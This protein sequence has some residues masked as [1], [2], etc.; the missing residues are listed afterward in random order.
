MCLALPLSATVR[1]GAPFVDGAVLQAGRPVPVWGVA[2]GG[3]C[4][5]VSFAGQE[6][7]ARADATGA[8]QVSLD[9]MEP[10]SEGRVLSAVERG[11]GAS[12]IVISDVLVGEVWVC[13]GQSNAECPLWG[14][15]PRFRD[16]NGALYAML[17]DMPDVRYVKTPNVMAIEPRRDVS[18]RWTKMTAHE[19]TDPKVAK[20]SAMG[21]YF[22]TLLASS[23]HVPVGL[24]DSTWG[25]TNI[26]AWTPRSGYE[27]KPELAVEC[28]WPS[29]T[30]D[31]W[32]QEMA[33][34]PISA[35]VQQPS[36]LWNAMVAPYVPMAVRGVIWYQG[37]HNN[38][39]AL[40]YGSKLHALY[41]G[42]SREFRNPDLRFRLVQLAPYKCSW[43]ELQL[44]QAKFAAEEKNAEIAIANDVG[45]LT[46]IHPNDKRTVAARLVALTLRHDY[47]RTD[48][49]SDS[50]TLASWRVADGAFV[51][52]FDHAESWFLYHDDKGDTSTGFEIAGADGVWHKARLENVDVPIHPK[53]GEPNFRGGVRGRELVVRA[54]DV[55]AP[56]ALRYLYSHP[57]FGALKNEV[58]LPLGAFRVD[59]PTTP[60]GKTQP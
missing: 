28:A 31:A 57:W 3:A 12:R 22:A 45:N 52:T 34:G 53:T 9:A 6:K 10:S 30:R 59:V 29:M 36:V 23:L 13:S 47:G 8:W 55:A 11:G 26:D 5:T 51:L 32:R 20:P 43:F 16:G 2:A 37:C 1:L 25:G 40:R 41:D 24:V 48:V 56:K 18:V 60:K 7:M 39:E 50:P 44:Q 27:G 38:G 58:G 19:L 33:K 46:D 14:P 42:W 35:A 21:F 15:D 17:T 4:V 49:K 54:E